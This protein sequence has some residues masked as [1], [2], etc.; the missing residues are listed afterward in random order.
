MTQYWDSHSSVP[1]V[2]RH[3]GYD[4]V[5]AWVVPSIS[6]EHNVCMF[7]LKLFF[8]EER[9]TFWS[10]LGTTNPVTW[11]SSQRTWILKYGTVL[12]LENVKV[13]VKLH[14][15]VFICCVQ[16]LPDLRKGCV[17]LRS[18]QIKFYISKN[19]PKCNSIFLSR[20]QEF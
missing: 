17:P 9:A 10:T 2:S 12:Y 14:F 16:P 5:P 6:Q 3:L 15:R 18:M 4:S 13:V 20:V 19:S 11:L 1:G 8:E 7:R